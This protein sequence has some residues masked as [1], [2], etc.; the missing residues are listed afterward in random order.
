VNPR[1]PRL[2]VELSASGFRSV[3]TNPGVYIVFWWRNGKPV[4]ISRVLGVDMKGV[5]YIGGT[6]GSLRRRLKD[7]WYSVRAARKG[8]HEWE[9]PHTLGVSLA[10]TGLLNIIKDN[11]LAIY[12]KDMDRSE[13]ELQEKL[14]ILE[15]TRRYGEPPP[16]NLKIGRRYT[17]IWNLSLKGKQ[18]KLDED[19]REVLDL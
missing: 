19:L 4:P 7:L 2:I 14:A 1:T 15:Y 5:L 9:Y 16:L 17:T 8:K 12:Y 6:T 13:A 10:Y 18:G 3:P 11:E